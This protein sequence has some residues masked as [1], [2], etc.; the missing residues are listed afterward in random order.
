V[1]HAK[2]GKS[3]LAYS[4]A[5]SVVTGQRWLDTFE[6]APG[7]VLL[8]D[9][10]LHPEELSWRVPLVAEALGIDQDDYSELLDVWSLRGNLRSIDGLIREFDQI[11]RG[12]Y[13][14]IVLDAKYRFAAGQDE[15]SN[16][17]ETETY[18][19]I[20][21]LAD[22]TQAAV[23]L[24]H[25]SAKGSQSDKSI[26]D[27]GAGAGAQARAADT[28]LVLRQHQQDGCAG[29]VSACD[30]H[31]GCISGGM[32]GGLWSSDRLRGP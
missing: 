5:L 14:L 29:E 1:S 19:L 10:E 31:R 2:V 26:V 21:R 20:D 15:N 7:R 12:H 25:H 9:N 27:V 3:W 8:V 13:C 18:N 30:S 17:A 22:H 23:V 4:L 6:C 32:V 28:H 11:Q 24:V 16:T